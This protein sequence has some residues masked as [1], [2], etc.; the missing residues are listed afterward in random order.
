MIEFLHLFS[1]CTIDYEPINVL[2]AIANESLC[3]LVNKNLV[4]EHKGLLSSY[5]NV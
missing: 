3:I 1:L 5:T 4:N 2:R